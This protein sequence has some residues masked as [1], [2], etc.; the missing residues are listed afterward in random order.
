M[1]G[2]VVAQPGPCPTC[3]RSTARSAEWSTGQCDD[4]YLEDY[5]DAAEDQTPVGPATEHVLRLP[6]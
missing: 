3:G 5:L 1:T 2:P 4:C 6:S